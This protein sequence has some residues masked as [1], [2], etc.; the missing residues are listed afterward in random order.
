MKKSEL[1]QIINE[2]INNIL[3]E[4]IIPMADMDWIQ[5]KMKASAEDIVKKA[6]EAEIDRESLMNYFETLISRYY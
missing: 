3:N 5:G 6:K 1:R 2:E 4:K